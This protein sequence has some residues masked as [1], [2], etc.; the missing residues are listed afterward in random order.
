MSEVKDEPIEL[1]PSIES[2]IPRKMTSMLNAPKSVS[3]TKLS[4]YWTALVTAAGFRAIRFNLE[5]PGPQV[6][7][8]SL[9]KAGAN[10]HLV[11]IVDR[12]ATA[13]KDSKEMKT[14]IDFSK[15]EFTEPG[16]IH[17]VIWRCRAGGDQPINNY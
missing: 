17:R 1:V 5:D 3:K 4:I 16:R 11:E 9:F 10:L 2:R 6:L 14:T 15:P 7:K 13:S 8:P 12:Y